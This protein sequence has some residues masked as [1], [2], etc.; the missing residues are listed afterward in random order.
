MLES[1]HLLPVMHVMRYV[2][3]N[4]RATVLKVTDNVNV[5][6]EQ[7]VSKNTPSTLKTDEDLRV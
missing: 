2:R 3:K 4:R 1:T 6:R 5:G 7:T